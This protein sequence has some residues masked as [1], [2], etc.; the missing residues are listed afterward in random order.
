MISDIQ[1]DRSILL[2]FISYS[3]VIFYAA[4]CDSS[5]LTDS[6]RLLS[7]SVAAA[8]V[9]AVLAFCCVGCRVQN[10]CRPKSGRYSFM[11]SEPGHSI[12]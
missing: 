1:L 12:F 6:I 3:K 10:T 8:T 9:N 4:V 5:A 7:V 2:F 11:S